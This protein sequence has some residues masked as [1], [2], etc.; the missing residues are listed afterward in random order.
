MKFTSI[1]Q[2]NIDELCIAFESLLTKHDITFKY[3]DM[4]EDNGILSFIFCNDP[5]KARSVE[6]ESERFIGLDTDY[7]AK[8]ILVPILPRLKEYAQK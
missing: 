5:D 1:S 6:L 8:E 2:L 4:R 7:I 3:V